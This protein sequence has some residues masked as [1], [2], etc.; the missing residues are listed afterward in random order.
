MDS[1]Q[2]RAPA[3][4]DRRLTLD[5]VLAEL[6][7]TGLLDQVTAVHI[8]KQAGEAK[9]YPL[10]TVAK[11]AVKS[12]K[13]P[14]PVLTLDALT[15][16]LAVL[17]GLP[18]FEIDALRIDLKGVSQILPTAYIRR[19][20]VIPVALTA[21]TVTFATCEPFALSWMEEVQSVVGKKLQIVVSSPAPI[22]HFIE[23][24]FTVRKATQDFK[25]ENQ[26]QEGDFGRVFELDQMLGKA[27]AN[28]L[29]QNA[30][31]V[32]RIVDWLFQFA[33]DERA[34][35]IHMEP[36]T[37]KGHVRFRID[38][39][40]R[41]VYT[42]EPDLML[43][44]VSRIKILADMQVDER[45]K[46]QDGRIRYRISG[47]REL[48]MRVST[49]PCLHGEKL[50]VRIFDPKL[51]GKGF[52]DLGFAPEDVRRWESLISQPHGIVLV[53][54]PTGSGKSTT[55]H[56]SLRAIADEDVNI[57]TIEDPIEIVNES[58]NQMQ[59]NYKYEITFA[60]AI[61][62]FMRQDPDVIM[63]GEIRDAETAQMA[64]QAALTGHLVLSTL[65]TNDAVSSITRL[66]D[67]GM[68]PHLLTATV[69]GV[70][71][72]RLVRKLC[73]SCKVKVATPAEAW[74]AMLRNHKAPPP[75]HV[76]TPGSCRDCKQTGYHGRLCVYE[77]VVMDRS[78]TERIREKVPLSE[79]YDAAKGKYVPL[80]LGAARKVA[81]G[82]T[83]IEEV[84]RV[85]AD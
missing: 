79:L 82:V 77:M 27:K 51:A 35:D 69:R 66:L 50:V 9:E 52:E 67:L 55:L 81:E 38:G 33:H 21:D 17:S 31:A 76:Y 71:A 78:I 75:P 29:G 73:E 65:H 13:P 72:Q 40:L 24:F 1:A 28:D 25:R 30:A 22:R 4:H 42:F 74:Q 36:K 3:Q 70:L 16:W 62:A 18:Y 68:P 19:L 41:K 48:E 84:L 45:R 34:T 44:I 54:G 56:T 60:S 10:A 57:S 83:S 80:P 59:V 32:V 63:V 14:H 53:T 37:G 64:I 2:K 61:R 46:P 11:F 85:I 12:R 49:I 20:G 5:F 15:E 6:V 26:G 8:R 47:D 39:H 7:R 58:L 23:E 43:P